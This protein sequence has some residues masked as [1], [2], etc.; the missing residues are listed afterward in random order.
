MEFSWW[1]YFGRL[2]L[3]GYVP[4]FVAGVSYSINIYFPERSLLELLWIGLFVSVNRR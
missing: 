4:I 2:L 3:I 1:H